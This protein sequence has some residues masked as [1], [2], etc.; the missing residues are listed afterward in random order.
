MSE[1]YD[2]AVESALERDE[3]VEQYLRFKTVPQDEFQA[4]LERHWQTLQVTR[5]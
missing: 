5:E 1:E 3:N 2:K 4:L